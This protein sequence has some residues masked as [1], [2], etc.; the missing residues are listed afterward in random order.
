MF[1]VRTQ[2]LVTVP[3]AEGTV[4]TV[5]VHLEN[6]D[7]AATMSYKFQ[8]SDDNVTWTDVAASTTLAPLAHIHVD[9]IAHIMH[10][11]R[12]SGDLDIAV[13]CAARTAFSGTISFLSI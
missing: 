10:R 8:W 13:E 6:L 12:A 11:L 1:D 3:L 4:L 2:P 9:L 5:Q 7:V